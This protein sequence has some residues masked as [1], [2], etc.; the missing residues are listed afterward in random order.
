MA[1]VGLRDF[2]YALLTQDDTSGATY[3]Q[4]YA[5]PGLRKADI[6]PQ[7]GT[8]TLYADDGPYATASALGEVKVSIE[9]AD[10]PIADQARILGH[11]VGA[12][13]QMEYKSSDIAP[14]VAIAFESDTHDNGTMFVKLVKG[15]FSE[16]GTSI[17]TK[18]QTPKFQTPTIVGSFVCRT[19]D[20]VWKQIADTRAAGYEASVGTGWYSM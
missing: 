18:E 1:Q 15:K 2:H 6:Q 14:Y 19:Y 17:E 8:E 13:G 12:N 5:V 3:G 20:K 9:L 11:T 7:G 16:P 10:L 4:M